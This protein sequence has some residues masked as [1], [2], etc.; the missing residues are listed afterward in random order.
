MG[1]KPVNDDVGDHIT[2]LNAANAGQDGTGRTLQ[3]P[4]KYGVEIQS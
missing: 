3:I 1:A 2:D 4:K